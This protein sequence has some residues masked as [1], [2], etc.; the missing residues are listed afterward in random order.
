[1]VGAISRAAQRKYATGA[2]FSGGH[3]DGCGLAHQLVTRDL[4][5]CSGSVGGI[6]QQ[7]WQNSRLSCAL[8]ITSLTPRRNYF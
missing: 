3:F 8:P 2:L 1:V 5:A 7:P 4:E 6:Q